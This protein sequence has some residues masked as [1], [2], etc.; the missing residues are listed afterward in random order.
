[1]GKNPFEELE[2]AFERMGEQLGRLA[3]E[4]STDTVLVDVADIGEAYVVTADL[5]GYDRDEVEVSVADQ[6][7]TIEASREAETEERTEPADDG[8]IE[9]P[10]DGEAAATEGEHEAEERPET[11][12]EGGEADTDEGTD[13]SVRYVRRERYRGDARR[14]AYLPSPVD[15]AGAEASL[16]QGVLTVTV[17][18]LAIDDTG[19]DIP[20]N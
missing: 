7:L 9:I 18:K 15:A 19:T 8:P 14:S 4:L 11:G 2:R 13:E 5:P 1:M 3:P 20:V 17:P 12:G 6:T 10:T 16:N